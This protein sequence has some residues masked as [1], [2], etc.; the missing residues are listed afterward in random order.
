MLEILQGSSNRV[1]ELGTSHR[2]HFHFIVCPTSKNSPVILSQTQVVDPWGTRQR[3][4][5]SACS[6][7]HSEIT[8]CVGDSL[9]Y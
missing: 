5:S 2:N 1:D 7:L 8:D 3:F 9:N 4:S 6:T